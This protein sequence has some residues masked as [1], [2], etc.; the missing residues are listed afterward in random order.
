MLKIIY[1]FFLGFISVKNLIHFKSNKKLIK[2]VFGMMIVMILEVFSIGIIYPIIT[3]ISDISFLTNYNFLKFLSNYEQ[4]QI[5]FFILFFM[6]IIFLIKNIF[7]IL[8]IIYK[9]TFL[10]NFLSNLRFRLYSKYTNQ[11]YK[12]FIEKDTPEIIR[13]IHVETTVAMRS[14][15]AYLSIFA[16]LFV[17]V[18]L[19]LFLFFLAPLPTLIIAL[20][21]FFFFLIY[22]F[23]LKKKIFEL[24]KERVELDSDLI[25][26]IEQGLGNYKEIIIY[27]IKNIFL[28]R[29]FKV[30]HKLNKNM[31]DILVLTQLT[32]VILE[33]FG[34]IIIIALA[35]ILFY[36]KT[37]FIDI[38][39]LL[40]S[41]VYAFFKILPSVNKIIIN[42]QAIINGKPSV[43]F[44]NK[45]IQRLT[46][47]KNNEIQNLDDNDLVIDS[48]KKNLIIKDLYYS[49]NNKVIFKNLNLIIKYKEKIGIIGPSG[50][51]KS[52][53]LNLIMGFLNADQGMIKYED[54]N[55]R[56]NRNKI[57]Y[58]SQNIYIM[59]ES[60]KNNI[61][62]RQESENIDSKKLNQ[63]I[64]ASG[65]E[66]FLSNLPEGLN[67]LISESG[68]NISGGELQRIMIARALYFS[69]EILIFDEFTSSLD[70]KTED[71]ILQ[72]I[73]R[74]NKTMIIVSHKLTSL[75]Y[76]D[77]IYKLNNNNLE[78]INVK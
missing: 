77:K 54:I 46:K 45:E 29:F 4:S 16:E 59:K 15:D 27:N 68:Y 38:I 43:N 40:G 47:S 63:V 70:P 30:T 64:I 56:N 57:G 25:R 9:S 31:R 48:F 78:L 14:L 7:I 32:R 53:L 55:I 62:L 21:F 8:F 28:T 20:A 24:G 72:G 74:I 50:S 6:V 49:H 76:C 66:S 44:L 58:V 75:K 37:N 67:T 51:G 10:Q 17:L 23:S 69:K 35:Y 41:Y 61:T 52:T 71:L 13:N 12:S 2:F 11:H 19:V 33:Q 34:I 73:N 22:I 5:I 39:P 36:Q 18:G 26:E 60:L 3:I 65:L 1:N 42:S